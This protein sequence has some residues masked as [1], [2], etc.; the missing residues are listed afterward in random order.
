MAYSPG[1]L[2]ALWDL[3]DAYVPTGGRI[4]D[5]GSQDVS[6]TTRSDLQPIMS[7][8][9][10]DRADGLIQERFGD[11]KL[12]KVGDLF[13]G[14]RYRHESID[15]YPGRSIIQADLNS[16][17]VPKDYWGAFDLVANLGSSE[18][19]FN[20]ANAFRC[21]HDLTKLG[22][23]MWHNVPAVGYFNH[24]LYNYH[25][26]FFVFMARAN[27][28]E[29]VSAGISPPHLEYTIPKSQ[30]LHGTESWAGIRQSSGMLSVVM[31]KTVDAPF[32]LFTDYDQ[33]VMG[34]DRYDDAW[35]VMM[36]T[37]YDLRVHD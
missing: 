8:L 29:I 32:E 22:S 30:S 17:A 28:Y 33:S 10:G 34:E 12:W 27:K 31:R 2:Q 9:H 20:Q 37:R 23:V 18:H 3:I 19:I 11:G 36:R 15:L 1:A 21:I 26:L 4:L 14:S 13:E 35:S 25:P 16:F 6:A 5:I 7:M 24:G